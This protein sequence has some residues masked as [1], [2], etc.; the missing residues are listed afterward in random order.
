MNLL[1]KGVNLLAIYQNSS[2]MHTIH[3]YPTAYLCS[4]EN[5]IREFAKQYGFLDSTCRCS[6]RTRSLRKKT[7]ELLEHIETL[8]PN[9]RS[10][11]AMAG[12]V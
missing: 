2:C 10:Q 12:L 3:H 6:C 11:Y 7:D 1:H 9:A 8:Y 4:K 5:E